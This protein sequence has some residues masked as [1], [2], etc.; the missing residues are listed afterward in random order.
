ML[1]DSQ[2]IEGSAA[3][4]ATWARMDELIATTWETTDGRELKLAKVAIDS[5]DGASTMAVYTWARRHPGVVMATKGRPAVGVQ[6]AISQPTWQDIT[7]NGR[8]IRRGVKLWT[9]GTSMLKLELYGHLGLPTPEP[10]EPHPDNYVFLP[11]DVTQDMV[12]Q[13]VAEQLV[14]INKRKGGGAERWDKLQERNEELDNAVY[15]RAVAISL[16]VDRWTARQ[17][18][19]VILATVVAKPELPAAAAKAAVVKKPA[20]PKK[21]PPKPP[22]AGSKLGA[23][24]GGSWM[25]RRR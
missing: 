8:K 3:D 5:G 24:A 19:K 14:Q 15:A 21:T 13:L 7:V 2:R 1:V 4:A 16:G 23:R 9:V 11:D 10:G 18:E 12:K 20:A 17:W 6:Q 25:N 22:R